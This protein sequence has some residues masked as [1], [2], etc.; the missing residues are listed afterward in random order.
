MKTLRPL[1][2]P[3]DR[4]GFG[5][6]AA[7][8]GLALVLG[9]AAARA[10]S[11]A[12]SRVPL[13]GRLSEGGPGDYD[14]FRAAMRGHGHAE[15]RIEERFAG[16][17]MSRLPALATELLALG[18]DVLWST[19]SVASAAAKSATSTVP[20]V[21][22]SSDAVGGGLV[23]SLARPGGN[24]TGLTLIG[25]DLAG[26][27]IEIMHRLVPRLRRV[28]T[29]THGP[30]SLTLKFIADWN[31]ASQSAAQAL[32]LDYRF[33]EWSAD[34]DSWDES[35]GAL[36]PGPG[37][38]LFFAESPHL[39]RHRELLAR[40]LLKH[41]APAM[42]AFQSHVRAGALCAY[43]VTGKYIDERVAWYVSRI[44]GGAKPG[45]LPVELPT[46]Y[47]LAIHL[48]T[49]A[50]LGLRIP[51]SLLQQADLLVD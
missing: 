17:E 30:N 39:G 2:L 15:V 18:P 42:F 3:L 11:A 20:V 27:R 38:A 26:K 48:G 1:E 32:R 50:A 43:G 22:V 10:A 5:R 31:R 16:G 7:A 8:G 36:A 49:A 4:R 21:I 29:V 45:D 37:S 9:G 46:K 47:E 24:L 12:G 33:V 40:V 14:V 28:F 23:E 41:R 51:R 25:S 13:I 19:G 44:L 35:L 6:I 34:P